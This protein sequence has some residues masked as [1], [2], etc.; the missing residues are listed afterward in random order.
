M[1]C[2][3]HAVPCHA[4]PRPCRSHP[5]P[6]P[7]H[8]ALI[9]ICH[10]APMPFPCHV[11]PRNYIPCRAHAVPMPFPCHA[12]PRLHTPFRAVPF[13]DSAVSFVKVRVV[14]GK[15]RTRAG[16]RHAVSGRLMLVHMP[17]HAHAALCRGSDKF[18]PERHDICESNTAALC[19]LNG[20]DTIET[21]RGTAWQGNGIITAWARHGHGMVCVN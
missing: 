3:A 13:S 2:C 5:V 11:M 7:C 21:L 18:L 10:A 12:M 9:Q 16:R 6:L 17:C 14:A 1:L 19:K 4:M 8:A 20:K 15:G